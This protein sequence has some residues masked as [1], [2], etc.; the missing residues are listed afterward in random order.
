M[1][2]K[3]L[4]IS[5]QIERAGK[6]KMV[7]RARGI[8]VDVT[9]YHAREDRYKNVLYGQYLQYNAIRVANKFINNLILMSVS[10]YYQM[11]DAIES[12]LKMLHEYSVVRACQADV[13]VY[14][15]EGDDLE[16]DS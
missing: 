3:A 9:A 10:D 12:M 14:L 7:A 13:T 4:N 16:K 5:I 15:L 8:A 1:E 11:R 6:S 2:T